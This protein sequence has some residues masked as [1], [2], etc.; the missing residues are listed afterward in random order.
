MTL[1]AIFANIDL[2]PGGCWLWRGA[3]D[4][5]GYGIARVGSTVDTVQRWADRYERGPLPTGFKVRSTC[6]VRRCANP[7]HTE[8]S[9]KS[10]WAIF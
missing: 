3:V 5:D 8:R 6:G 4:R 7:E 9:P 2:G 10:I 1:D